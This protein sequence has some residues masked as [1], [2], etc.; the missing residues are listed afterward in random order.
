MGNLEVEHVLSPYGKYLVAS[1]EIEPGSGWDYKGFGSYLTE[2]PE[3]GGNELGRAIC[4]SYMASGDEDAMWSNMRTL[5][6]VDMKKVDALSKTLSDVIK[7]MGSCIPNPDAYRN[8]VLEIDSAEKYYEGSYAIDI[9]D[10]LQKMESLNSEAV[11]NALAALDEAVLYHVGGEARIHSNGL[12]IMYEQ[13]ISSA[14]CER[15]LQICPIPEYLA[16]LG[17]QLIIHGEHQKNYM[18]K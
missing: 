10:M 15:Y 6:V 3:C 12:S 14:G 2:N 13:G 7:E 8:M 11:N 5:S 9:G 16:Y 17:M 4:D 18:K 1:E